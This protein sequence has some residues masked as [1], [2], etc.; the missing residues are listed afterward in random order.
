M[1]GEATAN[2][3][4]RAHRLLC[5]AFITDE[6]FRA[7]L[8]S[9][10]ADLTTIGRYLGL[11]QSERPNITPYFD[12][13]FYLVSNPDVAEAGFDALL[14][15]IEVGAE[16][17]RAP[18]PLID[19][20]F[21]AQS[22]ALV[23]GERPSPQAIFELLE[24]DLISPSPYFD[25]AE[26]RERLGPKAPAHGMLRH[27]L[28]EG[29][30]AGIPVNPY[31]NHM[32]YAAQYPDVNPDPYLALRH[33]IILGDV[34]GRA[35]GPNFNGRLY[36]ARYPDIA[37][38]GVPPL[39]HFLLRGRE[40]G[41]QVPADVAAEAVMPAMRSIPVGLAAP[42]V[43][44]DVAAGYAATRALLARAR[45]NRIEAVVERPPEIFRTTDIAAA[46]KTLR[47][48]P[49]TKP[50]LSILIPVYNEIDY[51][52][53]CLLSVMHH[54]PDVP[55]EVVLADDCSTDPDARLLA[56][57]KNLV[58]V[59][60]DTNQGFLRN[61]NIA[62]TRCRGDYVLLLNNDA[63]LL[64]DALS[65]MVAALAADATL[66]AVGPKLLY[67]NGRLQEAGCY[68]KPNGESGMIGLFADPAE[69]GYC[70]DRDVPYTSGAALMVRRDLVGETLFDEGFRP[71]YCEDVDLCL[72][73]RAAGHR[74]RYLHEAVV[75]HHLS[76]STNRHSIARKMR[77]I[78]T[79]QQ[80]LVDQWGELIRDLDRVRVLAFYLPQFHPTPENDLWWGRGFTEWTNVS[81]A[82]PSYEGHYQPHLPADLG[83]YDLRSADA[84]RAQA[85]L[86]ARY[87]ID[88]FCV[89]YYNF[90]ARRVLHR[91][92][93]VVR[94]NPDIPFRWCLCWANENWTRHW[95]GG[96]KSILLEQLYDAATLDSIIADAV[97]QARDPRYIT[98]AGKPMV[99]VY[100]PLLLPD[101][102]AFAAAARAAFATA[103][104]PGVH[105]AYVE[106]MEAV[107]QSLRPADLGFDAAVE[108]PP[109]GLATPAEDA[110]TILKDGWSGYRYDYPATAATF[111]S[112]Q[113]VAYPRYPAIFP[114]WDNTPRQPQR[115]TSF[116]HATPEAFRAYAEE[117]IEEI[118][119]FHMHDERLLFVNAWNEWAEGAHL[120]PDT[121][122]GHRWLESLRDALAAKRWS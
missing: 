69:P 5:S 68:I 10:R 93:E 45:Q 62:F 28:T 41:R 1:S 18:H 20:R 31:F 83:F 65:R 114:S 90:G 84:L 12:R 97:D 7:A 24:Y 29:A 34:E 105:L 87:G 102:R 49:A 23:L 78:V 79:N 92:L 33:F 19:L 13:A 122:H 95:D 30:A 99:L 71:A 32:W 11:P 21:I 98:V 77:T 14:H 113:S 15:F 85:E 106:S 119:R 89:Y 66:G 3:V 111:T 47:F 67:P 72:R 25:P 54:A 17:L 108:F 38:A 27:F 6:Q 96:E 73:L 43:P 103:G 22:D 63:Q 16:E 64:P 70:Y 82:R 59:R 56:K 40:E 26:Y 109:H 75:V 4:M 36:R 60:Q 50:R 116:D 80:R 8:G 120:E 2:P 9:H 88:G 115:G 101:P 44:D 121:G 35:A 55:F 104:F 107:N 52:V 58:L 46:I 81:K 57:V 53:D 118:R 61:C 76:V 117:K 37:A 51:T 91:P 42:V 110:V 94:A 86:A 74:V 112:R 100:R 39:W 48:P